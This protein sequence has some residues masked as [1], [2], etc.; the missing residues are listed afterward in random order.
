[1]LEDRH[2][3]L[4]KMPSIMVLL[5]YYPNMVKK[6]DWMILVMLRRIAGNLL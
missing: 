2:M 5:E 6:M 4:T 3:F 1:M